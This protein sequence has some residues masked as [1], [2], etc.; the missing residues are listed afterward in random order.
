MNSFSPYMDI[1]PPPQRRL[2]PELD[3]EETCIGC[4]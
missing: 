1:L 4:Q 2:W 3:L